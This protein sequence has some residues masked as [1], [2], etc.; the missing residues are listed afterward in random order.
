MSQIKVV[1]DAT[2]IVALIGSKLSLQRAGTNY[3]GLC[4]FHS[5]K[6]PSFF[7]S[8]TMQRFRCF[9]CGEAGDVFEFLQKYEGMTFY[10]A[11]QFLAEQAGIKLESHTRSH[12]DEKREKLLAVLNLAKEYYHFLF[13]KHAAGERARAYARAR[14]LTTQTIELF[15]LGAAPQQWDGLLSYLHGKKKFSVEL[16]LE[17]GLVI[18]GKN[19]R[20]YDR[21]RDRLIFPLKNHRGQVVGFSGRLLSSTAKEAKYINSPETLLYHKSEMLY[22]YHELYQQIRKASRV[23]VVEGEFDV[24]SSVQAH[25]DEVVAIKGSALTEQHIK[26]L[27]RSAEQVLLALDT[28]SAGVEATKRSI[29]LL[30][31]Q[32]VE[33]RVLRIPDGKDP[34]DLARANPKQWRETT[35]HSVTAYEFLIMAALEAHD[36]TSPEGKRRIMQSLSPVLAELPH[37]VELEYYLKEL[38]TKL[39]VSVDSVRQDVERTQRTLNLKLP[40]QTQKKSPESAQKEAKS[41]GIA[42]PTDKTSPHQQKQLKIERALLFLLLTADAETFA[43]RAQDLQ[44]IS[45]LTREFSALLKAFSQSNTANS[46]QANQSVKS[47]V[48]ELPNDIQHRLFTLYSDQELTTTL[49]KS[50]SDKEWQ[51]LLR[52][53]KQVIVAERKKIIA[54]E[55]AELDTILEKTPA[56]EARQDKLLQELARL[57]V[58]QSPQT[59]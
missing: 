42:P 25:V 24:L 3:K 29:K 4:P 23:L 35:K 8:E 59:T 20:T 44:S 45:L 54:N 31:A 49:E 6:S 39:A 40:T 9:G 11:L 58:Q 52:E 36:P 18:R 22:G 28:D 50:H 17:A 26:L 13:T 43:S 32:G 46:T 41:P 27:K 12:E 47:L 48:Q 15:Q 55:L 33:L 53:L 16:L 10:E 37:A 30:Q 21:F 19:G 56:E 7:V 5:E 2:D 38:A 14:G 57:N 34:D 51:R 1:K